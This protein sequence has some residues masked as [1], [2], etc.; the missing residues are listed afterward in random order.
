LKAIQVIRLDSPGDSFYVMKIFS[1]LGQEA[2][3]KPDNSSTPSPSL[4]TS[5]GEAQ[6]R[7]QVTKQ[8]RLLQEIESRQVN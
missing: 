8:R 1:I 6:E 4:F 7:I 2:P 5:R 3:Q